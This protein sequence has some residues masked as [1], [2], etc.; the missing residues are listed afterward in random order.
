MN[1]NMQNAL[2]FF[3]PAPQGWFHD[4][5]RRVE[6]GG[7]WLWETLQGDFHDNPT[8]AQVVTGTVIS[9]IPLVDQ[10]CDVR[11]FVANCRAIDED[12]DNT[13]AWVAL[14][15][16]LAGTLPVLGSLAKGCYKVMYYRKQVKFQ[17]KRLAHHKEN[18][19]VGR[20]PDEFEAPLRRLTQHLDSAPVR[21]TLSW[22]R[23][24]SPYQ[25]MAEK[26]DVLRQVL[27]SAGVL[28]AMQ[29]MREVSQKLLE[30]AAKWGPES[31]KAPIRQTIELI[32]RTVG[33]AGAHLKG[34]DETA[35]YLEGL[36]N[37]LRVEADK[38]YR[39]RPG[40]NN[41]VLGQRGSAELQLF[42]NKQPN[43]VDNDAKMQFK[44]LK[45]VPEI[46]PSKISDGWPDVTKNFDTFDNSMRAAT[47]APGERLYRVV[48]PNSSDNSFFWM[49]EKEFHQLSSKSEW[50]RNF[51]VWK[52]WNENGEFVT[53]TVPR[54][55]TLKVWEGRAASQQFDSS[56][57][58]TLQ[59]GRE[60]IFVNTKD[61][62]TAHISA[63]KRTGWGY[64][65]GTGDI[66]LD[67][68]KPFLGLPELT[69][70]WYPQ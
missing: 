4:A 12:P 1:E 14:V 47:V 49:R 68:S 9:M 33:R 6:A 67:P 39:A 36:A 23:I 18:K 55:R 8:T 50:R 13:A 46:V 53:Y 51:S 48:D 57:K 61:L 44:P 56:S 17:E 11:D 41:H 29:Q 5:Q 42:E 31:I 15:V 40:E 34:L 58:Y 22:M 37:R 65:D 54:D 70:K 45:K 38:A 60:Q 52:H 10:I 63:R 26:L 62:D 20:T 24:H 27:D 59:G 2:A 64:D 69:H 3:S 32:D 66:D 19:D 7:V 30:R 35:E 43:W 28:K 16:T 21:K 25:Y